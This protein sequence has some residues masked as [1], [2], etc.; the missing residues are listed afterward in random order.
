MTVA[1]LMAGTI[2]TCRPSA[3]NRPSC[4]AMYKPA[5]SSAGTAATV[6][7][8]FSRPVGAVDPPPPF[9]HAA[10]IKATAATA[11]ATRSRANGRVMTNSLV[12]QLRTGGKEQLLRN[13]S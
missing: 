11:P 4:S 1:L 2:F 9:E 8:V 6:R 13:Q 10:A 12:V 3:A 7:F 5:E